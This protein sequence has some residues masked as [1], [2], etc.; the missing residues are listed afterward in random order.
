M[1]CNVIFLLPFSATAFATAAAVAVVV[2]FFAFSNLYFLYLSFIALLHLNTHDHEVAVKRLTI[3]SNVDPSSPDT[4]A[5][6]G[7]IKR[8]Q[9][10]Y[11]ASRLD[12]VI[13]SKLSLRKELGL[14]AA[15][16]L[17]HSYSSKQEKKIEENYHKHIRAPKRK[18]EIL[19]FLTPIQKAF[20]TNNR[21]E[22]HL[23]YI[24]SFLMSQIWFK[25][26][27]KKNQMK[28]CRGVEYTTMDKGEWICRRGDHSDAFYILLSG[29][30]NIMTIDVGMATETHGGT[31]FPKDHFGE[32][33]LLNYDDRKST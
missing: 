15:A 14:A 18:S 13:H 11:A 21:N 22:M 23:Q 28:I 5:L 17:E 19:S 26:I 4:A 6:R 29:S 24:A 12:Y 25:K 32:L 10:N 30:V 7:F 9:G 2:S 16:L 8:R 31:L 33:G 27:D 1:R 3:C 20:L